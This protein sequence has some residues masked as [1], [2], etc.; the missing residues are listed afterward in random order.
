MLVDNNPYFFTESLRYNLQ[1]AKLKSN[2]DDFIEVLKKV[3]LYEYFNSL[4]GLDTKIQ[5][6][7]SNLSGGQR[8]RLAI[9]RVLL[10][11]PSVLILDESI[12]NIDQ[13]SEKIILDV[14]NKLKKYTT[15]ILITHRLNTVT[16]ADYIYYL[17]DRKIVEEGKFDDIIKGDIF[18]SVYNYQR[19]LEMWGLN[20]KTN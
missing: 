18:S 11:K 8:Q 9:A 14:I 10:K 4:D 20:E 17:K 2:D 13:E 3:G 5:A 1:I 7:A 16:N 12:S 6:S 15:I 19:D